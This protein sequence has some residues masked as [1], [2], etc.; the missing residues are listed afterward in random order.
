MLNKIKLPELPHV[1]GRKIFKV[2][3][4]NETKKLKRLK[5]SKKILMAEKPSLIFYFVFVFFAENPLPYRHP[6]N[7]T[8][9]FSLRPHH[10]PHPQHPSFHNSLKRR[11]RL[12][13]MCWLRSRKSSPTLLYPLQHRLSPANPKSISFVIRRRKRK[14]VHIPIVLL[15]LLLVIMVLRQLPQHRRRP[16]LHTVYRIRTMLFFNELLERNLEY[17]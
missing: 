3:I 17:K 4:E 14:P 2:E 13:C 11:R 15:R 8:K 1:Y 9:S 6:R 5:D 7:T 16:A 10:R 12:W